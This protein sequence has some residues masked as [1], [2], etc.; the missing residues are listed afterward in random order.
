MVHHQ[1][2]SRNFSSIRLLMSHS[3]S[4]ILCFSLFLSL[5]ICNFSLSYVQ[6]QN[7][8]NFFLSLKVKHFW[9]VCLY[10][11]CFRLV[12]LVDVSSLSVCVFTFLVNLL[13]F[14]CPVTA[15]LAYSNIFSPYLEVQYY[16]LVYVC[17]Y[18]YVS[19]K[20]SLS[21]FLL[22]LCVFVTSL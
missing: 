8:N 12:I 3:L 7:S 15:F 11:E 18:F 21:M 5:C 16:L 14:L 4:L 2:M 19:V 13:S 17:L 10:F 1:F 9:S 20:V 22:C 6:S